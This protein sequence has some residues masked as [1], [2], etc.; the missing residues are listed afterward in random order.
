MNRAEKEEQVKFLSASLKAGEIAIVAG[1]RG[2]SV[3]KV[4]AL[5][6]DLRG[7]GSSMQVIKNS[8]G[9]LA[10]Q[11]ALKDAPESDRRKLLGALEGPNFVAFSKADPISL[12]K[13]LTKF[14]K[15]N[16]TVQ[17]K[18]AWFEDTFLE[19]SSVE[20][21]SRLPSRE[22]VL[23]NLLSLLNAPATRLLQ[24]INAPGTQLVRLL[25]AHR[26]EIEK[27]GA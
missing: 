14:C 19:K 6:K 5:R 2:V 22:E 26:A 20:E 10:V 24:M 3:E 1:F 7:A 9:R 13:T 18:G 11:N 12:A 21:L 23:A 16:E 8:L 27:K 17:I 4:T 15:D 25:E